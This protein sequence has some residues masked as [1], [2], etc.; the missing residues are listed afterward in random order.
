VAGPS[1]ARVRDAVAEHGPGSACAN[2]FI[3][4]VGTVIQSPDPAAAADA[5]KAQ[6]QAIA[7]DCKTVLGR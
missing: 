6:L 4:Q 5:A 2:T 1:T 3:D 7:T